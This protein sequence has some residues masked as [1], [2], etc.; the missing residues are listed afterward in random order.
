MEFDDAEEYTAALGLIAEGAYRKVALGLKLGVPKALG[1]KRE[2]WVA[3][4]GTIKMSIQDRQEAVKELAA[5][6][7]NNCEIA[8]VLG[9]T[10]PTVRRDMSSFDDTDEKKPLENGHSESFVSSNDEPEHIWHPSEVDRKERAERG[11]CVVA[12]LRGDVELLAWAKSTGRYVRIDR[13]TEWGNVF[14]M[15]ED[16]DREAVIKKFAEFYLPH[17][18]GLLRQLPNLRGKVLGCWCHPQD[19]HGQ[20]IADLVNNG[21]VIDN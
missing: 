10:E 2:D 15:P 17:K 14:E 8:D 5:D 3:R 18:D 20:V 9:V 7:F 16:G 11:E 19:C 13:Q 6:G 4:I 1:M 12:N 21:G